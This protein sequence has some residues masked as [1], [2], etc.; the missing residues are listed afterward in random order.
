MSDEKKQEKDAVGPATSEVFE[1]VR[2]WSGQQRDKLANIV[3][4]L[5]TSQQEADGAVII[6]PKRRD[7]LAAA[8]RELFFWEIINGSM[9]HLREKAAEKEDHAKPGKD[10]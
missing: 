9:E 10:A 3:E 4:K 6:D 1:I 8:A 2:D 5:K 7:T